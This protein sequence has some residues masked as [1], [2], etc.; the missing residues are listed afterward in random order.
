MSDKVQ[1]QPTDTIQTDL[2]KLAMEVIAQP[3][4]EMIIL[5]TQE[6]PRTDAA[7]T[8]CSLAAQ[9]SSDD[10]AL[11]VSKE[12][13]K[14]K[15]GF[16]DDPVPTKRTRE[17]SSVEESLNAVVPP[18]F[19]TQDMPGAS[20]DRP[21]VVQISRGDQSQL[22][23]G[24]MPPVCDRN[25]AVSCAPSTSQ[26]EKGKTSVSRA[27]PLSAG[28]V[29]RIGA[30]GS[31]TQLDT[32]VAACVQ[33]DLVLH[34]DHN[35]LLDIHKDDN[36]IQQAE[37]MI[38]DLFLHSTRFPSL[39]RVLTEEQGRNQSDHPISTAMAAVLIGP[40]AEDKNF[41]K[42]ADDYVS[43]PSGCRM[44]LGVVGMWSSFNARTFVSSV[45][46][47][48]L[49]SSLRI[50][51]SDIH[52]KSG[53]NQFFALASNKNTPVPLW[54]QILGCAVLHPLSN[55]QCV[56]D[57]IKL[58]EELLVCPE[59][60]HLLY[61]WHMVKRCGTTT[62]S[63]QDA[64]DF[65]FDMCKLVLIATAVRFRPLHAYWS[66]EG[67]YSK[68]PQP[69]SLLPI[70]DLVTTNFVGLPLQTSTKMIAVWCKIPHETVLS[71]GVYPKGTPDKDVA[72]ARFKTIWVRAVGS[73]MSQII[74]TI[75]SSSVLSRSL[76]CDWSRTWWRYYGCNCTRQSWNLFL[77]QIVPIPSEYMYGRARKGVFDLDTAKMLLSE[78][79][80]C[81]PAKRDATAKRQTLLATS[82]STDLLLRTASL[83]T[84]Q[85]PV[86]VDE[87]KRAYTSALKSFPGGL[88]LSSIGAVSGFVGNK[89]RSA[90]DAHDQTSDESLDQSDEEEDSSA[91]TDSPNKTES[92]APDQSVKL[93]GN[94]RTRKRKTKNESSSPQQGSPSSIRL[95]RVPT[96][97]SVRGCATCIADGRNR[98]SRYNCFDYLRTKLK[99]MVD[100]KR[101]T[102]EEATMLMEEA[103]EFGH[104][105]TIWRTIA[106]AI[107]QP[108]DG[109]QISSK[110]LLSLMKT[111]RDAFGDK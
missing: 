77:H 58:M 55:E 22:T 60:R 43:S 63:F 7:Q 39:C 19:P 83:L 106:A 64:C 61:D 94:L 36:G 73:W 42:W 6:D 12:L 53:L 79:D 65:V 29:F 100:A 89:P 75:H 67:S 109:Y 105:K 90:M 24:R 16:V 56:S 9:L 93:I 48:I 82:S 87:V 101:M 76:A 18:T 85:V 50:A 72:S 59:L 27:T 110:N 13:P 28:R 45:R 62:P 23:P 69:N 8:L 14:R 78:V 103:K 5:E 35:K 44:H 66:V 2:P 20:C 95:I 15:V 71:A 31:L 96:Q 68:G 4:C 41:G 74:A 51:V 26:Q 81:F 38:E 32:S 86:K 99:L 102:A 1:D 70:A 17:E 21:T 104:N 84:R 40:L 98:C 34:V 92:A 33:D 25:N 91:G 111:L 52:G 80:R 11:N 54:S 3:R 37:A 107:G 10:P 88:Y 46:F 30:K 57:I 47:W 97:E 49:P 108:S